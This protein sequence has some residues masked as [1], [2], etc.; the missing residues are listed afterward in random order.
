MYSLNSKTKVNKVFKLADLLKL[1]KADKQIKAEA[2]MIESVVLEHVI[3]EETIHIAGDTACREIYIFR[4][5]LNQKDTPEL[6]IKALDEITQLHTYFILE[7]SNQVKEMGIYREVQDEHIERGKSYTT[8]WQEE[9]LKELPYCHKLVDVY[10]ALMVSLIPL[11]R[12][13]NETLG[14]CLERYEQVMKL[15][16]EIE[17]MVHKAQKENQSRKKLDLARKV[18]KLKAELKQMI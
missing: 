13:Q 12:R 8:Q 17:V 15:E 18:T 16:K 1:I 9:A 4:I 10:E 2:K 11:E 3:N 14:Q 5:K 6:F 7:Y